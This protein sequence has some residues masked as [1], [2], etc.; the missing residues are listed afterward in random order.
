MIIILIIIIIV[1]IVIRIKILTYEKCYKFVALQFQKKKE[2]K[3][4]LKGHIQTLINN[5]N[6]NKY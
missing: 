5:E 6:M 3:N 2:G 4:A 1:V